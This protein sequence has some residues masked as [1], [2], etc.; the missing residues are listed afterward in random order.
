MAWFPWL[1]PFAGAALSG[2]GQRR[3]MITFWGAVISLIAGYLV[4]GRIVATL[5]GVDNAKPTP[6]T[7]FQDGVDYV[8]MGGGRTL[9][10]Q[11]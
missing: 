6:V 5:F 10:V 4:Y 7:L 9:L 1:N 11:F 2:L 3:V 8:P